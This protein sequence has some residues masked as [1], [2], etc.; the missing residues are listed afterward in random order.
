MNPVEEVIRLAHE[1]GIPVLVD[2]AQAAGHRPVD[3]ER[4][5]CDF[6]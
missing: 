1:R 6:Y 3:V 2:G 5:G 4:L